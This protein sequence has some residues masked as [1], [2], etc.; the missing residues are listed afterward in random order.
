MDP[1]D[2]ECVRNELFLLPIHLEFFF[3][4]RFGC[5]DTENTRFNRLYAMKASSSSSS[6][7]PMLPDY[8]TSRALFLSSSAEPRDYTAT[9]ASS[10]QGT[11]EGGGGLLSM[12][13]PSISDAF[14]SSDGLSSG[15]YGSSTTLAGLE[16]GGRNVESQSMEWS[17]GRRR[18]AA[19]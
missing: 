2:G 10:G 19:E 11:V 18:E 15:L 17:R 4:F 9:N 6:V 1:S 7:S 5:V 14:R 8:G 3:F 12:N 13:F 16:N